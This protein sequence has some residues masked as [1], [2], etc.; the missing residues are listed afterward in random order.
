MKTSLKRQ[1]VNFNLS[2]G[3]VRLE[4]E[5]QIPNTRIEPARIGQ[6]AEE[7]TICI[8]NLLFSSS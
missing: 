6:G 7:N 4:R 1:S 2:I 3:I 8:H 5:N